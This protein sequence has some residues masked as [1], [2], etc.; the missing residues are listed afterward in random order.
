MNNNKK[1]LNQDNAESRM[2]FV[3][4]FDWTDTLITENS[5]QAVADILVEYHDIFP[6][7]R[8]DIGMNTDFKVKLTPKDDRAVYSQNLPMRI[9]LNKNLIVQLALML[10]YGIITV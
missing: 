7:H 9:H 2:E 1:K 10:K 3:K 6:R 5:E 8:R 4:R